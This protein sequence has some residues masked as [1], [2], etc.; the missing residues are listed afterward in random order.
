MGNIVDTVEDSIQNAILTTI[1]NII[2][3]RIELAGRS[4]NTSSGQDAASVR[5][6]SD[7]GNV[8][9]LL[10][11]LETYPKGATHFVN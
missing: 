11:F 6:N 10:S 8:Y 5:V 9:G 7:V 3:Q 1:D 4:I 2:T